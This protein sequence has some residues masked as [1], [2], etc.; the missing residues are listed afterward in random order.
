MLQSWCLRYLASE[1][2][3]FPHTLH[4]LPRMIWYICLPLYFVVPNFIANSKHYTCYIMSVMRFNSVQQAVDA[5]GPISV[6][7][8]E[9]IVKNKVPYFDL[10]VNNLA[11]IIVNR[12]SFYLMQVSY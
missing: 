5:L 12:G 7:P 4:L 6:R 8:T 2:S 1:V 10:K 11:F 3:P 9:V